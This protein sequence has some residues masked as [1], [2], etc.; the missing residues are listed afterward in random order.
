[1]RRGMLTT[2]L[3]LLVLAEPLVAQRLGPEMPRPALGANAD[4]N[5]ALAYLELGL[6]S[7]AERPEVAAPA[8][9]WAARLDPSS[10]GALYGR[11]VA[12]LVRNARLLDQYFEGGRSAR[13]NRETFLQLDSLQL[14]ALLRD[15]LMYRMLDRTLIFAY[16]FNDYRNRGGTLSRREFDREMQFEM[17][18][19]PAA[20]KAWIYYGAGQFDRAVEQYTSA[21]R[22][23]RSPIGLHIER[24]RT[25][26]LRSRDDEAIRDFHSAIR[27]LR[28]RDER[29][30][31]YVVFYDSKALLLHSIGLLY[32]RKNALDSARAYFG[33]AMEE[34]VSFWPA[35]VELG[36]LALTQHDSVTAV[37]ELGL[38]AELAKDEPHVYHLYAEMLSATGQHQEAIAAFRR[39]IELEP[40]YA[41]P[42]FG[43][44][45]ALEAQG[46]SAAAA[47]HYERFLQLSSRERGEQ[48][49]RATS[50][51]A[52]LRP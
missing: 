35:H 48:R 45:T 30:G 33:R 19:E 11:K 9:Y 4:T 8:F 13:N 6:S 36:R 29:R 10:P 18:A 46:D 24:A 49:T 5:N 12:L 43:L 25:L 7:V 37:S 28:E 39:A 52:A 2:S 16:Y 17:A 31:E 40:F 15:P 14:R 42:Q 21:L 3:G 51:L 41:A 34:D 47:S 38:A 20:T 44:A 1:M 22:G 26:S 50:R 32:G 27:L 23:S